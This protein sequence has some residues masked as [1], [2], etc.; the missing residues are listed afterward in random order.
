VSGERAVEGA[1]EV[2][3]FDRLEFVGQEHGLAAGLHDRKCHAGVAD[4][5]GVG[6]AVTLAE[7]RT[8]CRRLSQSSADPVGHDVAVAIPV[9]PAVA[10]TDAVDHAGTGE[11]VGG[12]I[13]AVDRVGA[14]S[15]QPAVELG[16][17]GARDGRFVAVVSSATGA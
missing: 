6:G 14:V 5:V 12:G 15:D 9:G 13:A 8:W 10:E 1:V 11:P 16:G 3:A 2:D 7:A 17:D 4:H